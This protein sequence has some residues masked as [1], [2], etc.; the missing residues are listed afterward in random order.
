VARLRKSSKKIKEKHGS[1]RRPQSGH[2]S[3]PST[4]PTLTRATASAPSSLVVAHR[5][6]WRRGRRGEAGG[7]RRR[8]VVVA[9]GG[10]GEEGSRWRAEESRRR[11]SWL[12]AA[13][14]GAGEEGKQLAHAARR[15]AGGAR[16]RSVIVARHLGQ[17]IGQGGSRRR[18]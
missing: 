13:S 10:G 16:R 1:R 9:A 3:P 8:S 4:A 15:E 11:S 5:G 6:R 12:V 14:G 17:W 2:G 18:R 7:A